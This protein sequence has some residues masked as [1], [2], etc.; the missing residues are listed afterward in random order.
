M[1]EKI[2]QDINIVVTEQ[3]GDEIDLD[4]E[5]DLSTPA[6]QNNAANTGESQNQ[7][8][9]EEKTE[10]GKSDPKS[11]SENIKTEISIEELPFK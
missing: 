11:Q 7:K 8:I 5:L 3:N 9:V 2:K 1:L 10:D 4:L 6:T